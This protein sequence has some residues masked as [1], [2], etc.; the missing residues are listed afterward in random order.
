MGRCSITSLVSSALFLLLVALIFSDAVSEARG[1]AVSSSSGREGRGSAV[2]SGSGGF[3]LI[4]R[5]GEGE[6]EKVKLPCQAHAMISPS[7]LVPFGI[8]SPLLRHAMLFLLKILLCRGDVIGMGDGETHPF[9]PNPCVQRRKKKRRDKEKK[10]SGGGVSGGLFS[11]LGVG[12]G[13]AA[14]GEDA[15]TLSAK[16][17]AREA[18]LE[19][20]DALARDKEVHGRS[21]E[22]V[23]REAALARNEALAREKEAKEQST[24]AAAREASL[25]RNEA[26]SREKEVYE[27]SAAADAR[28]AALARKMG[29]H[30]LAKDAGFE[31]EGGGQER[32]GRQHHRAELGSIDE[33]PA[34]RTAAEQQPHSIPPLRYASPLQT[35][36]SPHTPS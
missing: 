24:I 26:L 15:E 22:A 8:P 4:L 14:P 32:G 28:K 1:H 6:G 36:L 10:S 9:K 16:K 25:A 33:T 21:E 5:G 11:F 29:A 23:A 12:G 17:L 31:G 20:D 13:G 19:R 35:P 3:P 18:A 34:W 7:S 27:Q 30:H 2:C